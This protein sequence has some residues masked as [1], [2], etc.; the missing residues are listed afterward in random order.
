MIIQDAIDVVADKFVY[1]NDPNV[2][3]DA[4]FVMKELDGKFHGDCEDFSLTSYWI[5]S[6]CNL[7]KFLWNLLVVGNYG[8]WMVKSAGGSR[9]DHCVSNYNGVWFDNWTR[10]AMTEEDFFRNTGHA[11]CFRFSRFSI[12]VRLLIGLR[13]RNSYK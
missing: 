7:L 12:A 13:F 5:L 1:T 2:T 9:G 10:R 4:W 3:K 6:G 11:K 8:L